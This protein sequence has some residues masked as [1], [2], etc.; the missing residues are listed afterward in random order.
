MLERFYRREAILAR[1]KGSEFSD[2]LE[3]LA[4]YLEARGHRPS[5]LTGYMRGAAHLTSCLERGRLSLEGLTA[6]EFQLFARKHARR[7]ACPP[8]RSG[9]KNFVAV[10]PH[11]LKV[12]RERRGLPP[13]GGM[14]REAT[15]LD[16]ILGAFDIHLRDECGLRDATGER[17]LR[18]LRAALAARCGSGPVDM[19]RWTGEDVREFVAGRAAVSCHA[20]Q[21][22][23]VALRS[24]LRFLTL[25]GEP[26]SHLAAAIPSTSRSRLSGLPRGLS[27][28]QLARLFWA[29]DLSTPIGLRTHAILECMVSLGLRAGEV[30]RLRLG[31]IDWREGV[32]RVEGHKGR[33]TDVLPMP[34]TVGRAVVAYLKRGRPKTLDDHVFVRHYLPVGEPLV[35]HDVSGSVRR[36]FKRA[37][38]TLPSMGAH[39]LRH[40]TASRLARA[41]V[42]LKYIADVMRHRDIDTTRVYAKV[43]WPRLAEVAL[44]WPPAVAS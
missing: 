29:V 1:I 35:S 16:A 14:P 41:G 9:G 27:D 40:T 17:Y 39:V 15:P 44:A 6:E 8:P 11:L 33:R 36:A 43:D 28:E 34:H 31:D 26:V 42:G 4:R 30:A 38:L 22:L 3:E 24:F 32:L 2:D 7:C 19:L 20:A 37:G 10:A 12:M 13:T 18:D 25:R 23:G 21:R 5:A